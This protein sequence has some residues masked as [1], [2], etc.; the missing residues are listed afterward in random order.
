MNVA[1]SLSVNMSGGEAASLPARPA[2]APFLDES[3]RWAVQHVG[4]VAAIGLL[5]RGKE[6]ATGAIFTSLR[7]GSKPGEIRAPELRSWLEDQA[8][9]GTGGPGRWIVIDGAGFD[10]LVKPAIPDAA[11]ALATLVPLGADAAFWILF[12]FG[13]AIDMVD[14]SRADASARILAICAG[15]FVADRQRSRQTVRLQ[16]LLDE[17][18]SAFI[19]LDADARI[20][21]TNEAAEQI[22]AERTLLMRGCDGRLAAASGGRTAEIRLAI[23]QAAAA[24]HRGGCAD[25][26]IT[27]PQGDGSRLAVLRAIAP[28][29]NQD[30]L[31][32]LTLPRHDMLGF[33]DGL[34]QAFG[35]LRSEARFIGAILRHGSVQV[36]GDQ[37]GLSEQTARTYL[38]RIYAKLG[39]HSQFELARLVASLTPP[40]RRNAAGLPLMAG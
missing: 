35:I 5:A 12:G 21:W 20:L 34:H 14:Q 16:T 9:Q 8:L 27:L 4:A 10:A 1:S 39:I 38:K 24:F 33:A 25:R 15:A 19:M 31:L 11:G 3:W 28:A 32:L 17:L 6:E 7:D 22:I 13:H 2:E 18:A 26:L 40:F 37:L 36:A 30:P 29:A 23:G